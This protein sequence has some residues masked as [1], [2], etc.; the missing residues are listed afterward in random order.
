MYEIPKHFKSEIKITKSFH[1]KEI[2]ILLLT[3][4]FLYLSKGLVHSSLTIP[5]YIFGMGVSIFLLMP[6]RSN[7][8]RKMYHTLFYAIQQNRIK[9]SSID[10]HM[11]ENKMNGEGEM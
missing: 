2:V 4:F 11:V 6:S 7:P 1:L 10:V 5:Y 8:K 3:A 9:Y